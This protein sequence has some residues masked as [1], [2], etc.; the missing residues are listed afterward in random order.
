MIREFVEIE[1][2]DETTSVEIFAEDFS[3]V[4]EEV[5][6]YSDNLVIEYDDSTGLVTELDRT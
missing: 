2:G 5:V 1:L 3:E 6:F 4:L